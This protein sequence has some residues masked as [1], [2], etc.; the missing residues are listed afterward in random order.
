M[1]EAFRVRGL[2]LEGLGFSIRVSGVLDTTFYRG[3]LFLANASLCGYAHFLHG[4]TR[5]KM[6]VTWACPGIPRASCGC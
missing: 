6:K 3:V 5:D 4:I 2:G 1:A